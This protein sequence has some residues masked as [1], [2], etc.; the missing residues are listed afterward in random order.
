MRLA[1]SSCWRGHPVG[2]QVELE[3]NTAASRQVNNLDE[4]F[5]R[6]ADRNSF[7]LARDFGVGK[8]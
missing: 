3:Y 4:G 8:Y 7:L 1:N 2:I 5:S 6:L